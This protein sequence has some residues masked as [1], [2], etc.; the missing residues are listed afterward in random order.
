[1]AHSL[2]WG[3]STMLTSHIHRLKI[4]LMP[5]LN[6]K[7]KD[8]CTLT[9]CTSTGKVQNNEACTQNAKIEI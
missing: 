6:N 9:Y 8:V 1:M 3:K 2:K 4:F 7:G 5:P